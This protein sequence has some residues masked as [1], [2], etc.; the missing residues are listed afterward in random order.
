[1]KFESSTSGLGFGLVAFN[2]EGHS[3]PL[4]ATIVGYLTNIQISP[5]IKYMCRNV[6]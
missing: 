3:S 4:F 1:M 6:I 5:K 2:C